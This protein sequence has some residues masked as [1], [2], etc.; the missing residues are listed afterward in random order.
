MSNRIASQPRL[1][2][3]KNQPSAPFYYLPI[4]VASFYSL[5]F[6]SIKS[7]LFR[8]Q[9]IVD[10]ERP[11]FETK[12]A[13]RH[14]TPG[15]TGEYFFPVFSFVRCHMLFSVVRNY[16]VKF[17]N[18]WSCIRF[19]WVWTWKYRIT[20]YLDNRVDPAKLLGL[21]FRC[22]LEKVEIT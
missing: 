16:I 9:T 15:E 21:L 14:A 20:S 10:F 17:R 4:L 12:T 8:G 5:F 11:S 3:L 1:R 13:V 6:I 18:S 22:F 7:P 19:Y 2:H